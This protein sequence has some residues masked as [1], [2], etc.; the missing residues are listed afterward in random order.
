MNSKWIKDLNMR[1]EPIKI[2]E[3]STDSILSDIGHSN[4]FLDI[5]PEAKEIKANINYWDYIKIKFLHGKG[6]YQQK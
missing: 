4:I 2:L 5:S 3:E 6:N 1:P